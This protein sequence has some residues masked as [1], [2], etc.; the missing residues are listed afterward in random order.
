MD[1]ALPPKDWEH[2][3]KTKRLEGGV[4]KSEGHD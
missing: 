2:K 1:L 4:K 3:G